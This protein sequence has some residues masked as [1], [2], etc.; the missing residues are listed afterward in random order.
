MTWNELIDRAAAFWPNVGWTDVLPAVLAGIVTILVS[1]VGLG[2]TVQ[3]L[4]VLSRRTNTSLDDGH[5]TTADPIRTSRP[6]EAHRA[7]HGRR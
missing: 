1:K 7:R 2:L 3:R 5:D 4:R 6:A